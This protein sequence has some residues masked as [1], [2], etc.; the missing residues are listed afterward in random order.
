MG[1]GIRTVKI[2]S[3]RTHIL[4]PRTRRQAAMKRIIAKIMVVQ[5]ALRKTRH[6]ERSYRTLS[7]TDPGT[8]YHREWLQG[9]PPPTVSSDDTLGNVFL[10]CSNDHVSFPPGEV[11]AWQKWS[12]GTS[13]GRLTFIIPLGESHQLMRGV[14]PVRKTSLEYGV[15]ALLDVWEIGETCRSHIKGPTGLLSREKPEIW[16]MAPWHLMR[17]KQRGFQE[18]THI[19][20]SFLDS[21]VCLL[22]EIS[23]TITPCLSHIL[24][25]YVSHT[26]IY[27]IADVTGD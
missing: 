19:L 13:Q 26:D 11:P 25:F 10:W 14:T 4:T 12:P 20:F 27:G 6:L 24:C 22:S 16:E 8:L 15:N 3:V 2:S 1:K 18:V 9:L 7:S 21:L 5:N 23:F 17:K